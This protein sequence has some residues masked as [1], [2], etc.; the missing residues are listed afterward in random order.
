MK[1]L[2]KNLWKNFNPNQ[3]INNQNGQASIGFM[4][5]VFIIILNFIFF[6]LII[7][8]KIKEMKNRN[9][10][11]QCFFEFHNTIKDYTDKI[12]L[13]NVAIS[14]LNIANIIYKSP[15][16]EIALKTALNARKIYHVSIMKKVTISLNC[17]LPTR[18]QFG[19]Y[20][21]YK[22]DQFFLLEE[23]LDKTTI[24]KE[25][26]WKISISKYVAKVR[27]SSLFQ[28]KITINWDSKLNIQ[29]IEEKI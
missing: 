27:R 8:T 1:K 16:T 6:T 11:Y 25:G 26:E 5:L 22:L 9:D 13:A 3:A 4:M 14:A 20:W 29:A 18:I 19:H 24:K 23:N 12:E 21:P 7:R 28:I 2:P 15:Q 10:I 17:S